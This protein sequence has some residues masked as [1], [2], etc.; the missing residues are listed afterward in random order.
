MKRRRRRR[1]GVTKRRGAKTETGGR[2][3]GGPT[4]GAGRDAGAVEF[5][6]G[7]AVDR[8]A[9]A[10]RILRATHVGRARRHSR[11]ESV[12]AGTRPGEGEDESSCAAADDGDGSGAAGDSESSRAGDDLF[13][14]RIRGLVDMQR[15]VRALVAAWA[16][17]R[18]PGAGERSARFVIES[19]RSMVLLKMAELS[20]RTEPASLDELAC[21]SLALQRIEV[22][23]KYRRERERAA[24]EAESA[25]H[26]AERKPPLSTEELRAKLYPAIMKQFNIKRLGTPPWEPWPDAPSPAEPDAGE[27]SP[28]RGAGRSAWDGPGAHGEEEAQ[29]AHDP[30]DAREERHPDA[31]CAADAGGDADRA[32]AAHPP[33]DTRDAQS[34]GHKRTAHDEGGTHIPLESTSLW[35]AG[36]AASIWAGLSGFY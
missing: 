33:D 6:D 14:A 28:D 13:T 36:R 9:R 22:A 31:P 35:N 11:A 34:R 29:G 30:Q 15:E 21:L 26:P 17:S 20:G 25:V 4:Q 32:S 18:E 23:D 16:E 12:A 24:A 1:R 7:D 5:E 10:C 2:S 19:V 27:P 8:V 3:A